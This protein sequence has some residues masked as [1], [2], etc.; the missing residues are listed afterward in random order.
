MIIVPIETYGQAITNNSQKV[1]YQHFLMKASKTLSKNQVKHSP[2]AFKATQ[3]SCTTKL[4]KIIKKF[5]LTL[6][7][8]PPLPKRS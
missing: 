4:M 3:R 6:P 7:L 8:L 1:V 2:P 5:N